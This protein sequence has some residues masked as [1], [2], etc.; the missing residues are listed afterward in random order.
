MDLLQGYV[1]PL[2]PL[3]RV[4]YPQNL[5]QDSLVVVGTCRKVLWCS[6]VKCA[7]FEPYREVS[8]YDG[9]GGA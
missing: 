2:N 3:C 7:G 8:P 4:H 1:H 9:G 6:M 5:G